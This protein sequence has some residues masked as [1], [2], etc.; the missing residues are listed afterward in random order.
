MRIYS[1]RGFRLLLL[2]VAMAMTGTAFAAASLVSTEWWGNADCSIVEISFYY[3]NI[4]LGDGYRS[5][6]V[7]ND[8]T[9]SV[10]SWALSGDQLTLSNFNKY[11]T[12]TFAGKFDGVKMTVTHTWEVNGKANPHSE[13]CTFTQNSP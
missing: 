3:N 12:D 9:D 7:Y 11:P 5:R 10:A 6:V 13:V 1:R 8:F 4:M 2:C